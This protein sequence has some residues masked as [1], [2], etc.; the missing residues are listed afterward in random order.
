MIRTNT[1]IKGIPVEGETFKLAAYADDVLIITEDPERSIKALMETIEKYAQVSGYKLNRDKSE[2]KPLNVHTTRTVLG[3]SGLTWQQ[4]PIKYLGLLFERDLR[5]TLEHNEQAVLHK[6]KER[7]ETT[8]RETRNLGG[9]PA[10]SDPKKRLFPA[11]VAGVAAPTKTDLKPRTQVTSASRGRKTTGSSE[12]EA[13]DAS[14]GQDCSLTEGYAAGPSIPTTS[15]G[16]SGRA[17][18][19]SQE[20]ADGAAAAGVGEP[21]AVAGSATSAQTTRK[22]IADMARCQKL[23][24]I[25]TEYRRLVALAGE[26]EE[27][28]AAEASSNSPGPSQAPR[29]VRAVVWQMPAALH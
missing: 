25:C 6:I 7:V 16:A 11:G 8:N 20:G 4:K 15:A 9:L 5:A 13:G 21:A 23:E 28:V 24:A 10:P 26:E 22:E 18:N 12:T 29:V 1:D 3:Q 27:A 2:C 14:Q 19:A 17:D